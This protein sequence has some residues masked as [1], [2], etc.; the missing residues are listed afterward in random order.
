MT[1]FTEF[2]TKLRENID[3]LHRIASSY[4]RIPANRSRNR[5]N[6]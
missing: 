1:I 2:F 5:P 4:T 3:Q 6:S